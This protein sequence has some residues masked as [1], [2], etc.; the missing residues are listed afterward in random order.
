MTTPDESKTAAPAPDP[1]N[2]DPGLLTEPLTDDEIREVRALLA[3]APTP[4]DPAK[5]AEVTKKAEDEKKDKPADERADE[6][7][8][9]KA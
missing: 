7:K 1:G 8:G 3:Q 4:V 5:M 6:S 9:D 2:T